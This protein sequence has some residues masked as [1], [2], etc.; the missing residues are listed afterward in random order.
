MFGVGGLAGVGAVVT[1]LMAQ[2][3]YDDAEASCSPTCTDSQLSSSRTLAWTSTALT[4]VAVVGAGIGA[5]LFFT[6]D[7]SDQRPTA[8]PT[9]ASVGFLAAPGF[10]SARASWRF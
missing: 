8:G 3:K 10:A 2:S 9:P 7:A 5:V 1:G 6:A 4:G